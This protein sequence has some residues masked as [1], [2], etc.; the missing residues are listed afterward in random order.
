MHRRAAAS[1]QLLNACA[2]GPVNFDSKSFD[3]LWTQPAI[4]LFTTFTVLLFH[5]AKVFFQ[6]ADGN[7]S[8][9]AVAK[10]VCLGVNVVVYV[11]QLVLYVVLFYVDK[12][13]ETFSSAS[14]QARLPALTCCLQKLSLTC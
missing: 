9:A 8:K 2:Q 6:H 5:W 14:S 13:D 11:G 3:L 1:H 7:S 4:F 12:D 10:W